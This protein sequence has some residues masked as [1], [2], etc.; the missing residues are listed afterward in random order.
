MIDIQKRFDDAY[1][2]K[3][4][5]DNLVDKIDNL[6]SA[7]KQHVTLDPN[8][9][10][11]SYRFPEL[12]GDVQR[13]YD[14]IVEVMPQ[15]RVRGVDNS[16]IAF[17]AAIEHEVRISNLERV[18][19]M[20]LLQSIYFGIGCYAVF[21]TDYEIDGELRYSGLTAELVDIRDIFPAHSAQQLHDH[22]GRNQC[23]YLFRRKVFYVDTFKKLYSD[24]KYNQS[25]VNE[26]VANPTSL[27]GGN[28]VSRNMSRNETSEGGQ[29][30]HYVHIMEY[31]DVVNQKFMV[32]ANG[33][34]NLLYDCEEGIPFSHKQLPFHLYYNY[35]EADSLFGISEVLLKMPYNHYREQF[36]N[37]AI[38]NARL[39]LQP[40]YMIDDS[41]GFNE[42]EAL[43]QPGG[44]FRLRNLDGR[45][46]N[47]VIQE[48]RAGGITNDSLEVLRLVEDSEIAVTG[49]DKRSLYANPNQL[50]T[51]TLAKRESLQ[52]RI[53]SNVAMNA[54]TSE[55]YL[56]YQVASFVKHELSNGNAGQF[57]KVNINGY[58]VKQEN[59]DGEIEAMNQYN[60][61]MGSFYNNPNVAESFDISAL[62][63][64]P[65]K[66]DEEIK[67]DR[68]DKITIL[69]QQVLGVGSTPE[70]QKLLQGMNVLELLKTTADQ[71][72]LDISKIFPMQEA[73]TG[74]DIMNSNINQII[75]GQAPAAQGGMEDYNKLLQFEQSAVYK[76]LDE[77]SKAAYQQYKRNLLENVQTNSNQEANNS[78]ALRVPNEA[79]L[80][81]GM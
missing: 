8:D 60:G 34:D 56:M 80:P 36:M 77:D 62:E 57:R 63:V 28:F 79:M 37:L 53:R 54:Q 11:T 27:D 42:E 76:E 9:F 1:N 39:S 67:R 64:V 19:Q 65:A 6:V 70:G 32:Y 25:V 59:K 73:P 12:F 51:Q 46:I 61:G 66:L 5:F 31:W 78:E 38:E 41:V 50:A 29:D 23:P 22:T 4:K 3:R 69:V 33:F 17:Q 81:G 74:K 44:H 35:K 71:L 20:A 30:N 58:E 14:S 16:A 15:M 68:L 52:K 21:P 45:P 47:Q 40:V 48:Y 49:D 24:E 55:F 10:N 43:L 26:V 18:K 7:Y 72:S 75:A 13:K 2:A